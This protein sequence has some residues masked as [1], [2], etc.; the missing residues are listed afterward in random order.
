MFGEGKKEEVELAMQERE[1]GEEDDD[2]DVEEQ[3]DRMTEEGNFRCGLCREVCAD[4]YCETCGR[5]ID[6]L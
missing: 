1:G 5:Q 3:R 6:V 2:D 4:D